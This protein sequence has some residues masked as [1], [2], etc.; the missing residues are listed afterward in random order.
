MNVQHLPRRTRKRSGTPP[1]VAA[2]VVTYNSAP[3]LP[4]LLDSLP[5]GLHGI[6]HHRVIVV[7]NDS[8]DGSPELALSHPTK[9]LVVRTGRNAGYAAGINAAARRLPS[10]AIMLILNPDI[11]LLPGSVRI[12]RDRLQQPDVGIVVPK[13]LHPDGSIALSLRR[14]PSI[15]TVWSE[16]LLGGRLSVRMGTGEI[17]GDRR[18]Y[19]RG[20]R[21]DWATGAALMIS[22][23]ARARVGP[24]DESFF[25]YSEEVDYMRRTRESGYKIDY[26]CAAQ[27]VHIGGDYTSSPSLSGLMTANRIRDYGR[28][29]GSAKRALF[30]LGAIVG[31]AARCPFGS[32]H[33]ACLKAALTAPGN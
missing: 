13:I 16:A 17:I 18:L 29:H 8:H 21:F 27:V 20:G 2:V 11:R 12:L 9:P 1:L 22:A 5:E 24:W 14:E 30:R 7:D 26:A 25:L 28:R 19:D 23:E 3:V 10:D 33:R 15:T 31:A 32:V 4:G 6:E